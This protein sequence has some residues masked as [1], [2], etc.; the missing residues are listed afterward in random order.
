MRVV[1]GMESHDEDD[2]KRGMTWALV[3]GDDTRVVTGVM[4]EM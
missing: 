3:R 1:H 4:E 2:L